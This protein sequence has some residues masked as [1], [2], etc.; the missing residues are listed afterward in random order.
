M[1]WTKEYAAQ[2]AR[3]WR[4]AHP[5]SYEK[6]GKRRKDRIKALGLCSCGHE[7]AEGRGSCLKCLAKKRR[8][9]AKLRAEVLSA[10]G[11]LC[12]CCGEKESLF[13]AIDHI[14]NDGA[15]DRKVNGDGADLYRY[16]RQ[17][18]FPKDR[19]QLLCHNCNQ[20]KR[21]GPCPHRRTVQ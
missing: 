3:E 12:T 17:Q 8:G 19:Y 16:L 6:Y 10:Y 15:A 2:Y 18:G 5:G 14:H 21:F 4:K 11:G 13:L 20:A 9:T 1:A 7:K